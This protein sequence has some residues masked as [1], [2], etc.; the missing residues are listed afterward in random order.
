MNMKVGIL[1]TDETF[2]TEHQLVDPIMESG[3]VVGGKS[4]DCGHL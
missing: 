1:Y 3:K 2:Y 4:P